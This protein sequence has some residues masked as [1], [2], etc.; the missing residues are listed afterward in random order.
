MDPGYMVTTKLLEVRIK[1]EDQS[2][3]CGHDYRW[4]P[5]NGEES[6]PSGFIAEV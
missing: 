1:E 4:A 6:P 2:Q 3:M 5:D